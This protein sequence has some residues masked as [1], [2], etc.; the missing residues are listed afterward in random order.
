LLS[1][2]NNQRSTA[3]ALLVAEAKSNPDAVATA[4]A[5]ALRHSERVEQR[6]LAA[7]LIRRVRLVRAKILNPTG[8]NPPEEKPNDADATVLAA[9]RGSFALF[10]RMSSSS[11]DDDDDAPSPLNV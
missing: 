10:V 9:R 7:V 11:A 8:K 1:T 4:L 2:D 3:E 6:S 5:N